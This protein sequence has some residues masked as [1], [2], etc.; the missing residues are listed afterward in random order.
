ME[1]KNCGLKK[2]TNEFT[3]SRRVT[4]FMFQETL[5]RERMR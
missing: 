5:V 3:G 1:Q 4:E 2:M